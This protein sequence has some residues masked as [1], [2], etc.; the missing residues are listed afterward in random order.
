[1]HNKWGWVNRGAGQRIAQ[2]RKKAGLTQ[3]G[4]A[5]RLEMSRASIA[6]MEAGNQAIQI[7]MIFEMAHHLQVPPLDLIPAISETGGVRD[8][9]EVET[10][11]LIR[12]QLAVVR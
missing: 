8:L 12:R 4:L 7:Q 11:E 9:S 3:K 10:V 6:N 2:A 5:D 1:M